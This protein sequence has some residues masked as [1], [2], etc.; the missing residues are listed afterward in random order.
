MKDAL[1]IHK[2]HLEEFC[3]ALYEKLDERYNPKHPSQKI[4]FNE[5]EPIEP[6]DIY[7]SSVIN[8]TITVQY[9]YTDNLMIH[10]KIIKAETIDKALDELK[11][12]FEH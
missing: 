10:S 1:E 12:F 6:E 8:S 9:K 11:P 5:I 7:I 4:V 2:Q 3:T